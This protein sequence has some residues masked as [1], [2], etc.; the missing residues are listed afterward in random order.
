MVENVAVIG[1]EHHLVSLRRRVRKPV[2]IGAVG[3]ALDGG[4]IHPHAPDLHQ[5]GAA[6]IEI[7]PRT[8]RRIIRPVIA[9]FAMGQPRLDAAFYIHGVDIEDLI[10]N[11]AIGE[12]L[13]VRRPAMPVGGKVFR[14]QPWRAAHRGHEIDGA[15]AEFHL[16]GNGV[17]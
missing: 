8:V 16:V 9:T 17:E 14:H 1:D 10:A 5:S 12:A 6:G 15:L 4:A 3:D 11:A 2:A 13:P 7:D